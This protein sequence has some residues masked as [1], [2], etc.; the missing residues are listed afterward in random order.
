[1]QAR[2]HASTQSNLALYNPGR[3]SPEVQN[4]GITGPTNDMCPEI[5]F[6]KKSEAMSLIVWHKVQPETIFLV[7][8]CI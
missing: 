2:K 1:M 5:F 8:M 4:R 6:L 3:R 7:I